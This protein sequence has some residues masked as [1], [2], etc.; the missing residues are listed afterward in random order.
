MGEFN[1]EGVGLSSFVCTLVVYTT[2][3][4]LLHLFAEDVRGF[5]DIKVLDASICKQCNVHMKK[6][7]EGSSQG[8]EIWVVGLVLLTE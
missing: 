8:R 7:N 5:R 6:L 4:Y 2:A 1:K 3:F